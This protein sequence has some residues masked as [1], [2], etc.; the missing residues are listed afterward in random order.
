MHGHAPRWPKHEPPGSCQQEEEGLH[1]HHPR[2]EEPPGWEE[3][4][5][6]SGV[7]AGLYRE[8]VGEVEVEEGWRW[9]AHV[10]EGRPAALEAPHG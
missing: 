1:R 7:G 5:S 6:W 4:P 8:E 2:A 10:A 3:A 9:K